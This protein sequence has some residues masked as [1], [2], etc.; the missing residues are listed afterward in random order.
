[1]VDFIGK[2]TDRRHTVLTI[3]VHSRVSTQYFAV[4]FTKTDK[5]IIISKD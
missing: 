1:M 2:P 4:D 5:Q 3:R